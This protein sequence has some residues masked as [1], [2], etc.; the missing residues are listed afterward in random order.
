MK[1]GLVYRTIRNAVLS[2]AIYP[3]FVGKDCWN[4]RQAG[5][6]WP[7]ESPRAGWSG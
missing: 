2:T 3:V 4:E 6:A 7:T 1:F 5:H